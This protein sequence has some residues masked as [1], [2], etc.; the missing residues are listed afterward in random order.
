[1]KVRFPK[2]DIIFDPNIFPV[3]TGMEE[4]RKNAIHFFEATRWIR[5]NLPGAHVSGGVSNVSFS[6]RGNQTV[7]EAM[8][9]A[10]L[11]HGIQAGMDMGIVNPTLLEVYD[12]VQPELLQLVEDVLLDRRDDATERLLNYA[13]TVKDVSKQVEK[14]L[15]W[16]QASVE[17]RLEHALVK[18]ITEFID[19]DVEVAFNHYGNPL[20]VIEGP[21][22][23]G[24]N[25]VGDLFGSG[26]M[27]LPQVVKSA[28]VMKKAVSWLTPHLEA[29]KQGSGKKAGTIVLATV[30]GDV[31]D[32]GKNIVGV[33]LACNNFE[34]IDLGVM[35]PAATII[36]TAIK[37]QA[38]AIGLSGLITPSLDEMIH[39][40]GEMQHQN[41][42]IPL[43]IGGATT[44]RVHT[45][46][47][48]D[49]K[50]SQTVVH[51]N[52][53]SRAVPALSSAI[54]A[55]CL[56]F[57]VQIK[58]EYANV[59]DLFKSKLNDKKY[60]TLAEAQS[61]KP[62]LSFQ[63]ICAPEK[64]GIHS[65]EL[66]VEQLTPFIDW[67][68][69]FRT[70]GLA[71]KF[72]EILKDNVVGQQASEL[73]NEAAALLTSP[74]FLHL[75]TPKGVVGIF[76]ALASG[77][78][79]ELTAGSEKFTFHFLRQQSERDMA[80]GQWSLADFIAQ[81]GQADTDYIGCF[82]VTA[83]RELE[84]HADSLKQSGDDYQSILYKALGDRL[85]EAG[86][87][88]LHQLVRTEI[89][90]YAKEENLS[91]EEL[92]DEKYLGIRPAP[93]YP[94]CPDHL[95]KQTIWELLEVEKRT[96]MQLTESLAMSPAA[97]V[98][99]YY[100]AHPQAKYFGIGKISA[101]Q[102]ESLALR[103][104]ITK[105]ACER[106]LSSSLNYDI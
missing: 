25:V 4:H 53:A 102:V 31:H 27:F 96:G 7:R 104:G 87:E 40:A 98:C 89:W 17:K 8:H 45:A 50:Y 97:S 85:A 64:L 46:V 13:E 63:S 47:K 69:F 9:A 103:R 82:A 30:K 57:Q 52:D 95:D 43:L 67:T 54:G 73:Y 78:D 5:N 84:L 34:I 55:D 1:E 37:H 23:A 41:L 106:W 14:D 48:I 28:R 32:I 61:R 24:M 59:R 29:Q 80:A 44:S 66:T 76:P 56:A 26:K 86:A 70:W 42:N 74:A 94:A 83:G 38:D 21:L 36:E 49:P 12:E 62:Q 93:G 91:N 20:H 22:M 15:S 105:E 77:E 72:P 100:F 39:V 88:Y 51:V 35:V 101:D 19:E 81:K 60:L 10:F 75:V 90:G 99:G 65:I 3:A 6:F 11:Y 68:P 16:R 33:V 92:I 79:V 58:S 18:G 2:A 71:G